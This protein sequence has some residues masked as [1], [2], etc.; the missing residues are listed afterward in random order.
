MPYDLL[1]R[2]FRAAMARIS[3][4]GLLRP[5]FAL[6]L[7]AAFALGLRLDGEAEGDSKLGSLAETAVRIADFMVSN[8]LFNIAASANLKPII[9]IDMDDTSYDL[10]G[11]PTIF[12][13]DKLARILA[14]MSRA[15]P[16]VTIVDVDLTYD[17]EI[18]PA[19]LDVL[20]SWP[21]EP[22]AGHLVLARSMSVE[23]D[24]Y[25]NLPH[26]RPTPLEPIVAGHPQIH[27][28]H[29]F[30][31][32][33]EAF[34]LREANLW[35]IVCNGKRLQILPSVEL[36]AH[37]LASGG[38]EHQAVDPEFIDRPCTDAEHAAVLQRIGQAESSWPRQRH[39]R[40][41][42]ASSFRTLQ[43]GLTPN[44]RFNDRMVPLLTHIRAHLLT[45][46]AATPNGAIFKGRVAVVSGSNR[47][48]RDTHLTPKGWMP[49]AMI[50]INSLQTLMIYGVDQTEAESRWIYWPFLIANVILITLIFQYL[51]AIF[52]ALASVG[53][54]FSGMLLMEHAAPFGVIIQDYITVYAAV[55]LVKILE[56]ALITLPTDIAGSGWRFIYYP[57][58]IQQRYDE[59]S[60][61]SDYYPDEI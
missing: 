59:K 10:W 47:A 6:V 30:R 34:V 37:R 52:A 17:A 19:L 29:V 4:R 45:N 7:V 42:Y 49:G 36:V 24:A 28:G 5:W 15:R 51:R 16:R 55:A 11:Q 8:D 48:T 40:V 60:D 43:R 1:S 14:V 27:W 26:T 44:I 61:R 41:L 18:S 33:D 12:P 53:L 2:W 32:L 50:L 9:F 56:F 39:P 20:E 13:R 46:P 31:A 54:T 58:L 3:R 38:P 25:R 23:G 22:D 57:R 35:Q 21:R